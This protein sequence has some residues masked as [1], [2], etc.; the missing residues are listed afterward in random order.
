ML[1]YKFCRKDTGECV[2]VGSTKR[3]LARRLSSHKGESLSCPQ[4][5]HKY[6]LQNGGW[7]AYEISVIEDCGNVDIVSLKIRERY[8]YDTL[9]PLCNCIRPYRTKEEIEIYNSERRL[10]LSLSRE[11]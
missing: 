2:Y 3:I 5:F 11:E 9:K 4:P 8:W 1:V 7:N 6:V 10:A